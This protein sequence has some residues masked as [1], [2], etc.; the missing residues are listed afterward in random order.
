MELSSPVTLHM[1]KCSTPFH[2][3]TTMKTLISTHQQ[4][5]VKL[6]T[7]GVHKLK[8]L[9]AVPDNKPVEHGWLG[10]IGATSAADR[11]IPVLECPQTKPSVGVN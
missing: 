6:N 2:D 3:I 5:V 9:L 1:K 7:A 10:S 4:A 11:W 8:T